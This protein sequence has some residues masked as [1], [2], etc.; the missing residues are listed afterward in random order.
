MHYGY[1]YQET[2]SI[3]TLC[4]RLCQREIKI[5]IILSGKSRSKRLR[6]R[7]KKIKIAMIFF[8]LQNPSLFLSQWKDL[9]AVSEKQRDENNYL[10]NEQLPT[11]C[12]S[13]SV[14][15]L[16]LYSQRNAHDFKWCNTRHRRCCCCC[17]S[18]RLID[19]TDFHICF[20]CIAV[21]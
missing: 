21:V 1:K 18:S 15:S 3:S 10:L 4:C 19:Y 8:F 2:R 20:M 5:V 14:R 7:R 13:D 17:R 16:I 12:F 9:C 11:R 6:K